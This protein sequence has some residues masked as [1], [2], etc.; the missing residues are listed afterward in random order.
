MHSVHTPPPLS[1]GGGAG[2]WGGLEP[3]TKLSK[4]EG[5]TEPQSLEGGCW[6]RGEVAIFT[7]KI[8]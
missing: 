2:G 4:R 3:P 6:E 7:Y 8:N 5:L 1:A